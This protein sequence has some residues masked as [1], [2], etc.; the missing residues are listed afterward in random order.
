MA[1]TV[2]SNSDIISSIGLNLGTSVSGSSLD[3]S[4]LISKLQT[5]EEQRLTPYNNKQTSLSKQATA[6]T[7]VESAMKNL[8]SATTTLQNMKTITSTGVTSTNTAFSATTDSTAV[9]GSYSVFVNN[10]AQAQSQIS[11]NFS[12]A[13]TAL[14]SGGT[15][16]TSST[17]TITQS[18]QSTP[19]T[20]TLTDDKTSLNDI[21]DAINNAGGSVSATILNDGTNNKLILTAKDTGTKSAM[22]ISVGGSLSSSL[23]SSSFS[24][25]VAAKDAS[26]TIN[27]VSVTSQSNTVTTAISGVTLNL[28]AASTTGSNAE[29]L[30]IASDITNTEKA[31]QNWVTAY[32]NVLDVIKTQTNYTAPTSTEQSSG[33]QSSSN[34]ALVS[35]STIRAVKRQLQGLMSNFQSNGSLNTMADLGITQD[36]TNDGKLAVDNTKLESTLKSSASSVTQFFVGNGTTTGFATQAGNYLTRTVDS[37]DGLIKSAQANIKTSQASVTKQLA[38]IQDSIDSTMARY[39]T[40][41]TNLNTLLSKLSSTSSYLTQQFNKT[42]S[43][44]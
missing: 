34:G 11:G 32:N 16:S 40:Q 1:T 29:S 8:Q 30:T 36:P 31:V 24:E 6:Y 33:S 3:L 9:A 39:K 42:S 13:S 12:S 14:V 21:R 2:S 37:T 10:I 44:S 15:S 35:D 20:I 4:S 17:I 5:V 7:T 41:F 27:G 43:S 28:K 18:S 25:Q 26:F 23:S 38:S 22:S 19:L